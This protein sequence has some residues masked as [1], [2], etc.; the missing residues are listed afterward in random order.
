MKKISVQQEKSLLAMLRK[1]YDIS[2]I[3]SSLGLSPSHVSYLRR[4]YRKTGSVRF[5]HSSRSLSLEEKVCA[6]LEV[7]EKSLSLSCVSLKYQ[8]PM[9][10][11]HNWLHV[12]QRTGL[13]GLTF[14]LEVQMKKGKKDT[15]SITTSEKKY[16]EAYVKELEYKLLKAEAEIALL[17]KLRALI[18]AEKKR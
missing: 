14:L 8:I 9:S 16:T 10:T 2:V 18:Q 11:L 13:Q 7:A 4:C 6:V 12:Y 5:S 17:K 1:D 15:T 3:S